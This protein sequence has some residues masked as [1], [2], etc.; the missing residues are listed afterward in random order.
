MW[1]VVGNGAVALIHAPPDVRTQS[2]QGFSFSLLAPGDL[3]DPQTGAV[4]VAPERLPLPLGRT[5]AKPL[6]FQDAFAAQR[7]PDVI[8][9]LV[10]A[11]ASEA[12][13]NAGRNKI[14][15]TFRTT[16]ATKAYSDGR[17]FTVLR[18]HVSIDRPQA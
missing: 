13:A 9:R 2:L 1:E 14:R 11:D 5:K 12:T 8:K 10:L 16:N 4:T 6:L 15:V 18:L 17:S 7:V 3:F